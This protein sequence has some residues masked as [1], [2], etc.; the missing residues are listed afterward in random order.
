[1]KSQTAMLRG[2]VW[3]ISVVLF[4]WGQ[5]GGLVAPA[6]ANPDNP[7]PAEGDL[8]LPMPQGR[9]MVFRPVFI[10]KG[11]NPFVLRQFNM[12][13]PTSEFKEYL[14][15]VGIGGAFL[16]Q[17][18]GQRNWL[19]YLGKYEVTEAQYYAV[20]GPA[21][22]PEGNSR[23]PIRN[24]SW[25]EAQ[26]FLHT[27]NLWLFSHAPDRLPRC[28]QTVGFLRLPTEVEWE[29]AARGGIAATAEQFR[30]RHPYTGALSKYEWFSGPS[31]SHNTLQPVGVL[32]P[33]PLSLHDMLG[34][35][36]EMTSSLYQVEYYQGRI[37][38][39][40]ARGGHYLT[41]EPSL[42]ASQRVEQPFYNRK[43]QPQRNLT[44]GMRLAISCVIF[45]DLDTAALQQDWDEWRGSRTRRESPA[46]SS[47]APPTTQTNIELVK[48]ADIV[49]QILADASL[50]PD[51]RRQLEIV[52]ASFGN[53]E[54]TIKQAE[55][56]R[57]LAWIRMATTRGLFIADG[58]KKLARGRNSLEVATR[59]G[60]N[61]AVLA[62]LRQ[63]LAILH[64]N[65]EATL[66]E[67]AQSLEQLHK[68][69]KDAREQ[70]FTYY[71]GHLTRTGDAD[72]IKILNEAVKKHLQQY[73]NR[74]AGD[75][76]QWKMDFEQL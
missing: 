59:S 22:R 16:G 1:M 57:A 60:V 30:A 23:F 33:N 71:V 64:E 65:I 37:G 36:A 2:M 9:S 73:P 5:I 15:R 69:E 67:Y 72:R 28:G 56:D 18:N 62:K 14:T 40:V 6:L 11:E 39:F 55:V 66:H 52:Q 58:L 12:G 34:N 41:P 48:V 35:V 75:F 42:R 68:L 3:Y 51:T 21:S 29:F 13:D 76:A 20:M 26:E 10:G 54:A 38:G 32:A 45:T 27:Y 17:Q 7:K 53:I 70:A 19:Y 74:K 4:L 61:A 43:L 46:G 31:S 50:S 44:V 8:T 47:T 63:N 24:I 25:F 49:Q